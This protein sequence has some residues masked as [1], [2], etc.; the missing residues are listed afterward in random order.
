MK[1]S[2]YFKKKSR[3]DFLT[4]VQLKTKSFDEL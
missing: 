1:F 4:V 2:N 3:I